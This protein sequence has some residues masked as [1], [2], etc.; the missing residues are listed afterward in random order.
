MLIGEQQGVGD[1]YPLSY[2]KLTS[3]LAFYT[4]RDWHEACELSIKLLQNGIGHTMNIHTNDPQIVR[5]FSRKPASR[6]V[7]NTE[8]C[9]GPMAPDCTAR[10]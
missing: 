4:V 1:G 3:V 9:A 8:R 10:R 7:V 5:E 6:I 2:E